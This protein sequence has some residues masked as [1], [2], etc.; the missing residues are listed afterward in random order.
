MEG[1]EG[2][3]S[4]TAPQLFSKAA[5]VRVMSCVLARGGPVLILRRACAQLY[6]TRMFPPSGPAMENVVCPYLSPE[7][8]RELFA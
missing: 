4:I 5:E 7:C 8:V 2:S 6:L 3:A 1:L